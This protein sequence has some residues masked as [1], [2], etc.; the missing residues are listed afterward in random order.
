MCWQ[1]HAGKWLGGLLNI[2]RTHEEKFEV[3]HYYQNSCYGSELVMQFHAICRLTELVLGLHTQDE[4]SSFHYHSKLA[5]A[6]PRLASF[7]YID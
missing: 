1:H 4:P 2:T 7:G 5:G 3:D 6:P